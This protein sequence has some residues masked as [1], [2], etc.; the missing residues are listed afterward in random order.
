MQFTSN[1]VKKLI[2]QSISKNYQNKPVDDLS[3]SELIQALSEALPTI[4]EKCM[5]QVARDAI[6]RF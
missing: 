4:I 2:S 1:D 3:N 6:R 5:D